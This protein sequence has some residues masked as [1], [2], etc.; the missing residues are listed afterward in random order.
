MRFDQES[1]SKPDPGPRK[2]Q[3]L[4]KSKFLSHFVAVFGRPDYYPPVSSYN[5]GVNEKRA[6]KKYLK[7]TR[8][9]TE[10]YFGLAHLLSFRLI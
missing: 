6:P 1:V 7:N 8:K 10:M 4:T 2:V 5:W 3:S 9:L